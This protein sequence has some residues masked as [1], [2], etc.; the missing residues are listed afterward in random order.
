[1]IGAAMAVRLPYLVLPSVAGAV[2]GTGVPHFES[3]AAVER[4][5]SASGLPHTAVAS[6]YFYD[7]ALGG[8]QGL[9]LGTLELPLPA[10]HPLQQLD[11]RD[12]GAFVAFILADPGPFTGRR[13]ELASDAPR[14]PR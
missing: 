12:L 6:T 11:R 10:E 2:S 3:K 5:L 13:T 9:L 1:M 8:Y 14:Q 7:N 4:A